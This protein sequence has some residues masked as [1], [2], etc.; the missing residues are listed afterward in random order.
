MNTRVSHDGQMNQQNIFY[1]Y[2]TSV[3]RYRLQ[4]N[5]YWPVYLN[6]AT[7]TVLIITTLRAN[8]A[9]DKLIIFCLFF[10]ENR[11]CHF[12]QIVSIVDNLHEISNHVFLEK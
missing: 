3:S 9:D 2:R 6:E 12:K 5:E 4:V 10:Q 11:I 1:C 8:L 7:Y